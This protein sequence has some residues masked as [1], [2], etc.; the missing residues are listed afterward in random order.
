MQTVRAKAE[1][2][3]GVLE[4]VDS[5]PDPSLNGAHT[6]ATSPIRYPLQP[7][8]AQAG[9]AQTESFVVPHVASRALEIFLRFHHWCQC[10]SSA[11]ASACMTGLLS[12]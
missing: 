3:L 8:R 9:T 6:E 12:W 5:V 10:A 11:A 4:Q 7:K 1:S 2:L